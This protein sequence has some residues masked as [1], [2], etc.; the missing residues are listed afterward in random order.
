MYKKKKKK[1][2]VPEELI[3][4]KYNDLIISFLVPSGKLVGLCEDFEKDVEYDLDTT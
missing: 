1:D 2:K 3:H 4:I